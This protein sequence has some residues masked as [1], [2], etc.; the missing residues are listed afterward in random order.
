MEDMGGVGREG[1]GRCGVWGM[2]DM[3]GVRG[4]G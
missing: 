3:G 1:H 2:E 4:S